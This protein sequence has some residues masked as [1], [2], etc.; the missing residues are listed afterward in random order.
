M[1]HQKTLKGTHNAIFSPESGDGVEHCNSQD[2]EQTDLFGQEARP[3]SR[4]QLQ[5]SR[6]EQMTNDTCGPSGSILSESADLQS[7]LESRLAPLLDT[8]GLIPCKKTWKQKTTPAQRRYCQLQVSALCTKGTGSGSW[9]TPSATDHKG[10]YQGGRIRNGKWSADRLD[11]AAQLT[12]QWLTPTT[13]DMNGTR[14]L[15][16]KRSGGLNTQATLVNW[17]TPQARDYK[18]SSG[19]SLKGQEFD[20]PTAAILPT[21][22]TG[23]TPNKSTAEMVRSD[24]SQLNPRFSLW[25]MGY[26]IAW[27]YCAERVT[28]LSRRSQRKS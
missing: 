12:S 27:A 24:S 11:Q 13:S 26:P 10:G 3:A 23:I 6:K 7:Y 22:V 5:G 14:K 20:L 19:R 9:P 18:G 21:Q 8:D 25:L 16:G 28:P 17:P 4:S 1:S 15:D 2:G